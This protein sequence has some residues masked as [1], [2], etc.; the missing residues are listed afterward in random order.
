MRAP[1]DLKVGGHECSGA[2]KMSAVEKKIV[3]F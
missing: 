1:F 3:T 2:A